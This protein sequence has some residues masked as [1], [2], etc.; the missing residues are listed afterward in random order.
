MPRF[1]TLLSCFLAAS[2]PAP[3]SLAAVIVVDA[4]NGPGASFTSLSAAVTAAAP[5]DTLLVRDGTYGSF[6][7]YGKGLSLF[8][9]G[10]AVEVFQVFTRSRIRNVPAGQAVVVRGLRFSQQ[11]P[12]GGPPIA[13]LSIDSCDG[14]V[15]LEA[16]DFD[17]GYPSV[18][19]TSCA[20]VS[21]VRCSIL[22]GPIAGADGL[23]VNSSVVSLS[24][25]DVTGGDGQD[26]GL[27][28]FVIPMP[29]FAGGDGVVV[30]GTSELTTVA[31]VIRG[32]QGGDGFDNV[33]TVCVEPQNGGA[34]LILHGPLSPLARIATTS[35]TGG[36]PGAVQPCNT[37]VPAAGPAIQVNGGSV[38]TLALV[39]PALTA[40]TPVREGASIQ[41]DVA[42]VPGAPAL[43]LFSTTPAS[44]FV[45]PGAGVLLVGAPISAVALGP[46]PATS[47]LTIAIPIGELGP[48]VDGIRVHAQVATFPAAGTELGSGTAILL[49]DG[50]L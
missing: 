23:H 35:V 5:G 24:E 32:G 48:G 33:G 17:F 28:S 16:C 20:A 13:N 50:A 26:G 22:G 19:I 4:A 8:A 41:L 27:D 11:T 3:I 25:C 9:D 39:A 29:S 34:G 49:L 18:G 37:T 30:D 47:T 1:A 40:T 6:D 12:A 46:I 45:A 7:V 10:S 44:T 38:V 43:L 36:A 21:L 14:P 31:T 2:L 42:G 15:A